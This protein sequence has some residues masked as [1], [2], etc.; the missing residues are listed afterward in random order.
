[1]LRLYILIALGFLIYYGYDGIRGDQG[2]KKMTMKEV[3][4][5]GVG[6]SRYLEISDCFTTGAFVYEYDEDKPDYA[7]KVII[8]VMDKAVFVS[9]MQRIY[10]SGDSLAADTL[11]RTKIRLLV[12]R[13]E[14]KYAED[15]AKGDGSCAVDLVEAITSGDELAGFTIKGMT[16]IGIDELSD[17]D[18]DLVQSLHYDLH[19]QVILLEEGAE[20]RGT[21]M[22]LLMIIGG[23]IGVALTLYSYTLMK[24]K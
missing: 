21:T 24:K 2:L 3:W 19:D 23:V 20:P 22:S 12:Q 8:P 10:L 9:E 6:E 11:A 13:K 16:Q 4:E 17:K 5:S 14:G 1:M 18:K 15:C 7:T